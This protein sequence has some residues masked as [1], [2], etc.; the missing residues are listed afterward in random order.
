MHGLPKL[1]TVPAVNKADAVTALPAPPSSAGLKT[2][3]DSQKKEQKV[4][5]EEPIWPEFLNEVDKRMEG[6][7]VTHK[8][9]VERKLPTAEGKPLKPGPKA[10]QPGKKLDFAELMAARQK[11]QKEA[12]EAEE[13][14]YFD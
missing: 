10:T 9:L 2:K 3:T 11:K 7:V 6:G 13:G 14:L 8:P 5:V 12:E 4:V 1:K